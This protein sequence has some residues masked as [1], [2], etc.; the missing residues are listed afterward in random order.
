M[1]Q[2][3]IQTSR[4][5]LNL[6]KESNT[7]KFKLILQNP[8]F[9]FLSK[10]FVFFILWDQLFYNYLIN[11]E[12]HN[13]TINNLLYASK[14]IL[15][16]FYPNIIVHNFNIYINH[17]NCVHVGIPC[18]GIDAMGVFACLI[19]AY[20]AQWFHKLWMILTGVTIIF[21]LN[22][23]RVA[24]LAAIIIENKKVFDINHKYIFNFILYGILLILFS[25]WSS[26][27]GTKTN[28]RQTL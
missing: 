11:P 16:W 18:N 8:L 2:E 27:F 12:I 26:K 3:K 7:Q 25:L 6:L 20:R 1:T 15:N 28:K 10:G 5:K 22:T 13:W 21:T 4:M 17:R 9:I 14:W 19:L 23:I 24:A